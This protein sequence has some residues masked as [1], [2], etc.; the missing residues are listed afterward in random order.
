MS[1]DDW[2]GGGGGG[3]KPRAESVN[4]VNSNSNSNTNDTGI[5]FV[6]DKDNNLEYTYN[7]ITG[8]VI[9]GETQFIYTDGNNRKITIEHYVPVANRR[10]FGMLAY[11]P[12]GGTPI[13]KNGVDD[14]D[15]F[16]HSLIPVDE[17]NYNIPVSTNAFAG[18]PLSEQPTMKDYGQQALDILTEAIEHVQTPASSPVS[19]TTST[20]VNRNALNPFATTA[21][22]MQ[23]TNSNTGQPFASAKPIKE[24]QPSA[25]QSVPKSPGVFSSLFTRKPKPTARP[26][27]RPAPQL[28]GGR[29]TG[30]GIIPPPRKPIGS[31]FVF[32]LKGQDL[33]F[34]IRSD[35]TFGVPGGMVND[36]EDFKTAALRELNE[37]AQLETPVRELEDLGRSKDMK[38]FLM[39][40]PEDVVVR[41]PMADSVGEINMAWQPPAGV[42]AQAVPATGHW[43]IAVKHLME[44]T[45][46]LRVS[47]QLS[48]MIIKIFNML[49]MDYKPPADGVH[50]WVPQNM[51]DETKIT[52]CSGQ[53]CAIKAQ[54]AR[55][56]GIADQ[57]KETSR[58]AQSR[59][60]NLDEYIANAKQ[61]EELKADPVNNKQKIDELQNIMSGRYGDRE[62]LIHRP[63]TLDIDYMRVRNPY[64]AL[65]DREAW[66]E[67]DDATM[68]P[69]NAAV[70]KAVAPQQ[71][72]VD[73]KMAVALLESLYFCGDK[74]SLSDDP[75]CFPA[76][77]LGELR[78]YNAGVHAEKGAAAAKGVMS[79]D[80]YWE[81]VYNWFKASIP[82]R[83]VFDYYRYP[84][85]PAPVEA[86]EEGEEEE[87]EEVEEV[88]E[89][90][91]AE[92]GGDI[93][94]RPKPAGTGSDALKTPL[95]NEWKLTPGAQRAIDIIDEL[96]KEGTITAE[97]K[98][99]L[100]KK[101][102]KQ[103]RKPKPV[104]SQP[105]TATTAVPSQETSSAQP[106]SATPPEATQTPSTTPVTTITTNASSASAS[107]TKGNLSVTQ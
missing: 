35:G 54:V 69:Q 79:T 101:E 6:V 46:E 50:S 19:S 26:T 58:L 62:V 5:R 60:H 81:P 2:S 57:F 73:K 10:Q 38:F 9:K 71:M 92:T 84:D 87:V 21:P 105:A 45:S 34:H 37:E 1:D 97:K 89:E 41:G 75:R 3:G 98:D 74:P 94:I 36:G 53:D 86:E 59:G 25:Q 12:V 20:T 100:I 76:R 104:P 55:D 16:L 39:R 99:E 65:K 11:K 78:E 61:L 106:S 18:I 48:S 33:L 23:T 63:G 27:P 17:K 29:P 103:L 22:I 83:E 42:I 49:R 7:N 14:T 72:L 68:N 64:V 52:D 93:G 88:E 82:G 44:K 102:L 32:V 8:T 43:W 47:T 91:P 85:V 66:I 51:F 96:F 56:I 40:V 77:V 80:K 13:F 15:A 70:L 24:V 4:S 31:A 107:S 95:L 30:I 28:Q 90:T 67:T